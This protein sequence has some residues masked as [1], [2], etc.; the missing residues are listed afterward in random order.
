MLCCAFG[1]ADH[2]PEDVVAAL[3]K[4]RTTRATDIGILP[5][6]AK[7]DSTFKY[8]LLLSTLDFARN[9]S[10]LGP[11]TKVFVFSNP[12][13]LSQFR[14]LRNI[15]FAPVDDFS[16]KYTDLDMNAVLKG[17]PVP[18][19]RVKS[20]FLMRLISS[21]KHGSLLNPLMT[22]IY[23]LS[24]QNQ[25]TVK[26]ASVRYLYEGHSENLLI[27]NVASCLSERATEKLLS[28]LTTS[29]A[30]TYADALQRIRLLRKQRSEVDIPALAKTLSVSSYELSYMMSVVLDVTKYADS[31][32]K[33]KNRKTSSQGVP[34]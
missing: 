30:S 9:L 1:V 29:V 19:K 20:D 23:S 26:F 33:A 27:S 12:I 11:D 8:L 16:F 21:V 2:S 31:F 14:G 15:D 34:K 13:D 18:I 24:S 22:F 7:A 6:T 28:I 10:R 32:D 4:S 17:I 3:L 5:P 25:N